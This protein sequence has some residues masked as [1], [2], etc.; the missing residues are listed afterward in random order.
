[1]LN[2]L[3]ELAP[4]NAA[5]FNGVTLIVPRARTSIDVETT[6][7][8]RKLRLYSRFWLR[9]FDQDA[10]LIYFDIIM[11]RINNSLYEREII[12]VTLR[13]SLRLLNRSVQN[14][15]PQSAFRPR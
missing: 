14:G 5:T 3:E 9:I 12:R 13:K 1:M 4:I 6:A 8:P 2:E 10:L 7:Q 11:C 15:F